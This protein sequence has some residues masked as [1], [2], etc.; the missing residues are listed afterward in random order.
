MSERRRVRVDDEGE[1]VLET[2][3]QQEPETC[4]CPRLDPEDWDR[5]ESDWSDIAFLKGS[6]TAVVGVP[7]GFEKTRDE[8]RRRAEQLGATVP[9][10]AM[11]LLGGGQ[12]RRAVLLEIEGPAS[13]KDVV[14]PGGIAYTRL[15]EAPLGAIKRVVAE[16]ETEARE[17]YGRAPDEMWLWYLTC[18]VCSRER[19]FET[20]VLAHYREPA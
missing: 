1:P 15:L 5:V 6:T 9:E 14:R 4:D 12:F 13:A 8:L 20:L 19:N 11:V 17:R 3:E 10:D 7:T 2:D 18:R 16:T